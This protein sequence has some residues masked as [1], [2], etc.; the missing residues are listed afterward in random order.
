MAEHPLAAQVRLFIDD[1]VPVLSG[2]ASTVPGIR[3]DQL[4]ADATGEAWNLAAGFI[5]ADGNHTDDELTGL[6]VAFAPRMDSMTAYG[7]PA[8]LR[9]AGVLEGRKSWLDKPSL[10]FDT[11]VQVDAKEGSARAWG[12]YEGALAIAHTVSLLDGYPSRSEL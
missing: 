2:L 7:G 5:D 12:Y 10:L 9:Q 11:L 8:N 1:L 3:A 6:L 4:V